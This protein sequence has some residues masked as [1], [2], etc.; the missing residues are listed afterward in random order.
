MDYLLYSVEKN[1]LQQLRKEKR[2]TQTQVAD[3]LSMTQGNYAKYERGELDIP[4]KVLK[5]LSEFYKESI[6]YI[7]GHKFD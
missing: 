5:K 6:N 2:L 7:L 4:T 1:R 3:L